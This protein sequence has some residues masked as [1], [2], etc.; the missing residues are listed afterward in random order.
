[1]KPF[2]GG[3]PASLSV[4]DVQAVG[5][6]W[7]GPGQPPWT[8]VDAVVVNEGDNLAKNCRGQITVSLGGITLYHTGFL[9]ND[10]GTWKSAVPFSVDGHSQI[11][12]KFTFE[13]SGHGM[14]PMDVRLRIICD[15]LITNFAAFNVPGLVALPQVRL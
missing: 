6:N 15:D 3:S 10:E 13:L 5:T 9:V 1:M 7:R 4:R 12:F 11:V 8:V 2:S 14:F